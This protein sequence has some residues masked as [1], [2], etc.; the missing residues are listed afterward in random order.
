MQVKDELA[1]GVYYQF[2]NYALDPDRRTLRCGDRLVDLTP[3]VFTT[4]LVL[5]ENRDKVL[6]KDE[7]LTIIWPSQFVDQSN[8]SQN[9]SV[10][11]KSL[12]ETESGNKY[13]ATFPGRGYRF[14]GRVEVRSRRKDN[15]EFP[16][17]SAVNTDF[18]ATP[19]HSASDQPPH[20][21][22][23][24][25]HNWNSKAVVALCVPV[26]LAL[27]AFA[28]FEATRHFTIIR[29]TEGNAA[30]K[31]YARMKAGLTQPSWSRDGHALAFVA[32]D[33]SGTRSAIYVQLK[34]DIQPHSVVSDLGQY[35]SPAWSPDGKLLAFLHFQP[36]AAEIV[37]FDA[38]RKSSRILTRLFPHRYGLNYRH[39]DWSPD[40]KFLVVDDKSQD[41]EPFSLYLIYI[42]N[43]RRV[44]LTYP[45]SDII[46]DVS[47]RVSPDG[48][49]VAFI[50]DTYLFEQDLYIASVRGRTYQRL[51]SAAAPISDVGWKTN[52]VLA[53]AANH[54]DGF[55]FWQFDLTKPGQKELAASAVDS[56]RPLQFSV[57]QNGR[58]VAFSN[59]NPNLDI[60]S[61]DLTKANNAW[62]PV[63][64]A[65]GEN[66]RPSVSPDGTR[67]A[68]LSNVSGEFQVWISQTDGSNASPIPT[69]T[70]VP[71]SFCWSSDGNSIIFSPL[72][73][74]GLYEVSVPSGP[75]R[76]IS[77]I[78]TDPYNAI[79][80]KS[81]FVRAHLFIY[82]IPRF[83][84]RAQEVTEQGGAPIAQS[85]DG[86]YLYFSQG[87]MS[88]SIA[89]LDLQ[90]GH[91]EELTSSLLPGYS[92]AWA[93]SS[94]GIFFLGQE[95][96]GPA[97]R[98]FDLATDKDE[99]IADFPGNL[100]QVEMSGFGISPDGKHLWVVRADPMPS[101]IETT[102]LRSD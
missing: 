48:T 100:P 81:L 41:S 38:Q 32:M 31:V 21:P 23:S 11:R 5:V 80:N 6:T 51:T 102:M 68:F 73:V 49:R 1:T 2:D 43:G 93:L 87:R 27:I 97:I 28:I 55:K 17:P 8:L 79:D 50:R 46:G 42:E 14:V 96:G 88:T 74:H 12:G 57:A 25:L 70:L 98:F 53:L 91:Q 36:D 37:I 9:I 18:E 89:R 15:R 19:A 52:N 85:R 92:D 63:I 34:G 76:Q 20:R 44:R 67:L 16:A 64:Q 78:Y 61:I 24:I 101:D 62:V 59:Y 40:G 82:R 10:L 69:G 3:K 29:P 4:L 72:H 45:D 54:G 7:L 35:S 13:I 22:Q 33:L 86:R 58:L 65:P 83:G 60:W 77:S 84:G 26:V 47:P 39:L 71:T 75:V 66:I 90:T 95:R 56:D 94:R 30:V 99:Y